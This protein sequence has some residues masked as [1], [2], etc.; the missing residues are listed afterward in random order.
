MARRSVIKTKIIAV[1]LTCTVSIHSAA[2][3]DTSVLECLCNHLFLGQDFILEVSS[4]YETFQ[5]V[6]LERQEGGKAG[7]GGVGC[8]RNH[9]EVQPQSH[10]SPYVVYVECSS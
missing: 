10:Q 3:F 4:I 6:K 1:G 9:C 5:K 7:G 8:Q 2:G